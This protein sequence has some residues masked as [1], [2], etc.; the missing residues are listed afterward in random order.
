MKLQGNFENIVSRVIQ[1]DQQSRGEQAIQ[2]IMLRLKQLDQQMLVQSQPMMIRDLSLHD[3]NNNDHGMERNEFQRAIT[4]IDAAVC[5]TS[6][7][8]G[9][10]DQFADWVE[11]YS[12]DM[13]HLDLDTWDEQQWLQVHRQAWSWVDHFDQLGEHGML[14]EDQK[15]YC[16]N[17]VSDDQDILNGMR[18]DLDW[19]W[20]TVSSI[21]RRAKTRHAREF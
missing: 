17:H 14:S 8:A 12:N 10:D 7:C 13:T 21:N 6:I 11:I 2:S 4:A 19:A 5:V 20:R 18:V 15:I 3:D 9:L 1:E 16:G